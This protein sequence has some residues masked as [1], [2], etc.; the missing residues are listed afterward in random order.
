MWHNSFMFWTINLTHLKIKGISEMRI[1][2]EMKT[3]SK[4]RVT[5]RMKITFISSILTA[6]LYCRTPGLVFSLGVD[7]VLPL[8]Q[9][10]EEEEEEEEEPLPK[11]YQKGVC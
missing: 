6:A 2:S 1:F 10:E 9:E 5:L 3:A 7:F 4:M 11:I 8:S